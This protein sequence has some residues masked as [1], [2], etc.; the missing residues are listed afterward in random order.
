[1]ATR[2]NMLKLVQEVRGFAE[3]ANPNPAPRPIGPLRL[4]IAFPKSSQMSQRCK[5][6]IQV[7]MRGS[8]DFPE[9]VKITYKALP[10]P[11]AGTGQG[12]ASAL[13]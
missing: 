8:P 6:T 4:Q 10:A 12:S 5:R 7:I 2:M 9:S 13:V 3:F 1:M 11:S